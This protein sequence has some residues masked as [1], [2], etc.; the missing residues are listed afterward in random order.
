VMLVDKSDLY[1][2]EVDSFWSFNSYYKGSY[3]KAIWNSLSPPAFQFLTKMCHPN[4]YAL[5][6]IYISILHPQLMTPEWGATL[7]IVEPHAEHQNHPHDHDLPVQSTQHLLGSQCGCLS[8][9]QEVERARGR[10]RSTQTSSTGPEDKFSS[11]RPHIDHDKHC[12]DIHI[13]LVTAKDGLAPGSQKAVKV[14]LCCH[15][16]SIKYISARVMFLILSG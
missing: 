11:R 16:P 1:N 7:G 5:K 15:T 8:G 9:V 12:W 2:W 13:Q 4:I 3:F 14:S 10:T 6:G